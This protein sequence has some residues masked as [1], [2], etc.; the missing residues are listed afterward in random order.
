[1]CSLG[2]Q[3]VLSGELGSARRG[4]KRE[5]EEPSDAQA[6]EDQETEKEDD[7]EEHCSIEVVT[8]SHRIVPF[9]FDRTFV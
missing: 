6:G 9:A 8:G 2:A 1:M 3:G 4:A 7:H 5:P